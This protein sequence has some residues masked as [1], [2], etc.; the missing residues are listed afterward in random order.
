MY[1]V[2]TTEDVEATARPPAG[3]K[4]MFNHE[5][6]EGHEGL[7]PWRKKVID[8]WMPSTATWAAQA[9]PLLKERLGDAENGLL[10]HCA[11]T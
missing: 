7:T 4:K 6:Q 8:S 3:T 9:C 1:G 10:K 5:D 11:S 2:L